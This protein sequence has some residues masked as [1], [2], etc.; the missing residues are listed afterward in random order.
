MTAK[1]NTHPTHSLFIEH[2]GSLVVVP[3]GPLEGAVM[4]DVPTIDDS[5]LWIDQGTIKWFGPAA[6][7]P[8]PDGCTRLSA[9]L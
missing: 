1:P 9:A 2:I 3:P 5:A 6:D 7:A 4:R 8:R